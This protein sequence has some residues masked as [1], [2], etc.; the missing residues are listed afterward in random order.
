[1]AAAIRSAHKAL[2]F[3]VGSGWDRAIRCEERA[4]SGVL[5]RSGEVSHGGPPI[6]RDARTGEQ[7]HP[8]GQEKGPDTERPA[9]WICR[10]G[11][12]AQSRR[13]ERHSGMDPLDTV[14]EGEGPAD[15]GGCSK[16]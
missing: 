13:D 3:D 1:M 12:A 9:V 16:F 8:G 6:V 7:W 15:L 14:D 4:R 2:P 10:G 11:A 5:R